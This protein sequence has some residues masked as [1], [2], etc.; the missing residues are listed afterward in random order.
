[1]P[2]CVRSAVFERGRPSQLVEVSLN[3]DF[4]TRFDVSDIEL[5]IRLV[6]R[7]ARHRRPN[8]SAVAGRLVTGLSRQGRVASDPHPFG[9][10]FVASW[11]LA[12]LVVTR[13]AP[14]AVAAQTPVTAAGNPHLVGAAF[15]PLLASTLLV[16][17][18]ALGL[19]RR[20][21]GRDSR[22]KRDRTCRLMVDA[23]AKATVGESV[24][25]S[26]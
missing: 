24:G 23:E 22:S 11:G 21:R 7:G 19:N 15:T 14:A 25:C 6:V 13:K 12:R 5:C 2:S 1:M 18:T 9:H 10:R 16:V 17:A 8:W 3:V 4:H 26:Q 20:R